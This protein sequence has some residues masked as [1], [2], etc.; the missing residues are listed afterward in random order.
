M[1]IATLWNKVCPQY[2]CSEC[3]SWEGKGRYGSFR[4]QI[5]R[6]GV[7]VK[8][9]N[10]LR[11]CAIPERFWGDDSQ[12]GAVSSELTFTFTLE[13]CVF[14]QYCALYK[15]VNGV[16]TVLLPCISLQSWTTMGFNYNLKT[17]SLSL[18]FNGRFNNNNNTSIC[19]AHNVSIRAESEAFF[20]VNLG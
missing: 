19:K 2:A 4:L 3:Y 13:S 10:P 20:Q 17:K 12:R 1:I 18:G 11:T 5:K 7:Q 8:L 9:W 16:M 6:V 14:I 15:T